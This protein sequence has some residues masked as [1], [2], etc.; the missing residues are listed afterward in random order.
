MFVRKDTMVRVALAEDPRLPHDAVMD[1]ISTISGR[2][3][4]AGA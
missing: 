2:A 1:A 4:I 3:D